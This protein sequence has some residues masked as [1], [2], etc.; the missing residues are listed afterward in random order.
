M[1]S[2]S[3][4]R[5]FVIN[6]LTEVGE[7]RIKDV[8]LAVEKAGLPVK[9]RTVKALLVDKKDLFER[10]A[11]GIY[12]LRGR[13]PRRLVEGLPPTDC[14]KCGRSMMEAPRCLCPKPTDV[15]A[16]ALSALLGEVS[17]PVR[18]SSLHVAILTDALLESGCEIAGV[19]R[20]EV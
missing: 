16:S 1:Q 4:L 7:A 8:Q 3:A 2:G 11:P 14:A 17:G 6:Y 12:Q 18:A 5:P 9:P 20:V 15:V 10:V 19:R 13:K